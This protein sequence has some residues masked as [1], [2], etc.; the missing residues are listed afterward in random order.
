[1]PHNEIKLEP[2]GEEA[3]RH[4]EQVSYDL[5]GIVGSGVTSAVYRGYAHPGGGEGPVTVAVKVP[6]AERGIRELEVEYNI[7]NNIAAKT[8]ALHPK[9][10][11]YTP[12][13]SQW[14]RPD[15]RKV[16][17][18]PYYEDLLL[19]HVQKALA[20]QNF[21][22][23]EKLAVEAMIA[24]T[25]VMEALHM[26]DQTCPDRKIR[27]FYLKQDDLA[28]I[29]WNVLKEHSAER[30]A[31]EM[32]IMGRLWHELFLGTQGT[33][34]FAPFDDDRWQIIQ[35][36]PL[37]G[38]AMSLGLRLLLTEM[39]DRGQFR[40][41]GNDLP[42]AALLR[43][44]FEKWRGLL[45]IDGATLKNQAE[46]L[47]P[48]A[49]TV[50]EAELQT[51]IAVPDPHIL[52]EH[53][54]TSV[55]KAAAILIDLSWRKTGGGE[56]HPLYARRQELIKLQ[57]LEGAESRHHI[58]NL[59]DNGD[60]PGASGIIDDQM[61]KARGAGNWVEYSHLARWRLWVD[62][63][64][65]V[66][67]REYR[68]LRSLVADKEQGLLP[69]WKALNRDWV[70]D[71][72]DAE[73]LRRVQSQLN[74]AIADRD[75]REARFTAILKQI[76]REVDVRLK[77]Q[78]YYTHHAISDDMK[79]RERALAAIKAGVTAPDGE[80]LFYYQPIQLV[81]MTPEQPTLLT[82]ALDFEQERQKITTHKGTTNRFM[83]QCQEL[84]GLLKEGRYET[85]LDRFE[86]PPRKTWSLT[87]WENLKTD[88]NILFRI[89]Q[90]G[91]AV[92]QH[93]SE[94]PLAIA[95]EMGEALVGE[96]AAD[97]QIPSELHST[98]IAVIR[99]V[100]Q[101]V[102]LQTAR[103]MRFILA[104]GSWEAVAETKAHFN[105]IQAFS[106]TYPEAW[107]QMEQETVQ[108]VSLQ[109]ARLDRFYENLASLI[110]NYSQSSD[111]TREKA[112]NMQDFI[113]HHLDDALKMAHEMADL[114]ENARSVG[115]NVMPL[116]ETVLRAGYDTD[117]PLERVLRT[118]FQAVAE[119]RVL[120]DIQSLST[121]LY[122]AWGSEKANLEANLNDLKAQLDDLATQ[123]QVHYDQVQQR[124][125]Q[126]DSQYKDVEAILSRL[127]TLD[128]R[129]LKLKNEHDAEKTQIT[130]LGEK[131]TQQGE[132]IT[133]LQSA[134]ERTGEYFGLGQHIKRLRTD[135]LMGRMELV[136]QILAMLEQW[137]QDN[138]A[139][140]EVEY[141]Y[142]LIDSWHHRLWQYRYCLR[143]FTD[144]RQDLERVEKMRRHKRQPILWRNLTTLNDMMEEAES[145]VF[146]V[147]YQKWLDT[148]NT[149]QRLLA[150]P[151]SDGDQKYLDTVLTRAGVKEQLVRNG[152]QPATDQ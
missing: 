119:K 47:V 76:Q 141:L 18:M 144:T 118:G 30:L 7:L 17:V 16:L 91:L 24:F 124:I 86:T 21:V 22:E 52:G 69:I 28:V 42:D 61:P 128:D 66:S 51:P 152:P 114:L 88:G 8:R 68:V 115:A 109:Y 49:D 90:Y 43:A 11:A 77:V 150:Q 5:D 146:A 39:V 33:S 136:E 73:G 98:M 108:N 112:A 41:P 53:V 29:D 31:A 127:E 19:T 132:M 83:T 50:A 63:N 45:D 59:I 46:A 116:I 131:L 129:T 54:A 126:T 67:G 137:C 44:A 48:G 87:D 55:L 72:S 121:S 58:I 71:G 56:D 120:S 106:Q 35:Q 57:G 101:T 81:D 133:A 60:W 104:S 78:D 15:K 26:I 84:V 37:F 70:D 32:N 110:M 4:F 93:P 2:V 149:T 38:G 122:G 130:S 23:A 103:E 92:R 123:Y 34:P 75:E 102:L 79:Q 117:L 142:E 82:E 94:Y 65:L 20:G 113:D 89:A 95:A 100:E 10:R 111:L 140:S 74:T 27:D 36:A 3:T 12:I 80:V 151:I 96:V 125:V 14:I 1:M 13:V 64:Q 97:T 139:R 25:Y 147:L 135:F 9:N 40:Y 107:E 143:V 138:Q 105:V 145:V 99:G 134:Q 85:V 62:L 6:H 148:F